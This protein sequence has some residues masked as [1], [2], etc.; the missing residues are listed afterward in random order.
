MKNK[1]VRWSLA[2]TISATFMLGCSGDDTAGGT[3]G[4]GG[5]FAGGGS[6]QGGAGGSSQSL[7]GMAGAAASAGTPSVG[8][9]PSNGGAPSTGGAAG[10]APTGGAAGAA[11]G[12]SSGA[13]GSTQTAGAAGA[14]SGGSSGAAGASGAAG[15]GG[16]VATAGSGGGAGLGGASGGSGG[17]VG[18]LKATMVVRAAGTATPGD[19]V[20]IERLKANGFGQVTVVSDGK[21]TAQSVVGSDL[22]V[23]S[24]SAESGPLQDK[25]KS[26][27]I[28]VLCVEDAEFTLMGMATSA[29]HDASVSQVVVVP[30]GSPLVGSAMGTVMIAAKGG[31]LG[32]GVP[33]AAAIKGATMPG[34]A[35][36]FAVFGYE[37]GAQMAT[38]VAPAR[39]AGFAIRENLAANLN[40]DGIK[41]FD[42]IV[43][44][45]MQPPA[46]LP[47]TP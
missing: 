4:S 7:G 45:V 19:N 1:T 8:G 38:M 34:N 37:K 11:S 39:R 23:I 32:W 12:G 6:L 47:A 18:N 10:S 14:A 24:S 9:T 44:W 16:V 36:R 2:L 29:N 22:V 15:S 33:S 26:I 31:E 42:S 13:A 46:A 40:A 20:M 43:K 28:P 5:G 27:A 25:L 17:D 3:G 41:L 35:T 30:E 21:A